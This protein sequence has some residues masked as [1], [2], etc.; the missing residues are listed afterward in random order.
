MKKQLLIIVAI[1]FAISV[2]AQKTLNLYKNDLSVLKFSTEQIDSIKV[3]NEQ[4]KLDIYQSDESLTNVTLSEID[5]IN[6]S[7]GNLNNLASI[8]TLGVTQISFN[9]IIMG[10]E[11]LSTGGSSVAEMGICWNNRKLPT[12]NRSVVK[13]TPDMDLTDIKLT[14]LENNTTYYARAFIKNARGV[15]YGNELSFTTKSGMPIIQTISAVYNRTSKSAYCVGNLVN[16]GTSEITEHGFCWS[17]KSGA[18]I[19]DSKKV[20]DNT[21]LGQYNFTIEDLNIDNDYFVR[22]YA[23]NASGTTYGKEFR[24]IPV[25]GNITY[26]FAGGATPEYMG[27]AKFKMLKQAMDS[28][29]Y[30]FNKYTGYTA[31]IRVDHHEGV[32]TAEASYR[33]Q[34]KFGANER[35]LFVG[36]AMHEMAHYF[37]S[38]THWKWIEYQDSG[39][40]LPVANALVNELTNGYYTKLS[41]GG[42][43]YWPF[44]CN[45]REE[46]GSDPG[47]FSNEK[48]LRIMAKLVWAMQ[49]DCGWRIE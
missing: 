31:N 19:N 9:N 29:C 23:T 41:A 14:G 46:V 20:M 1:F 11:V 44:G 47:G 3:S 49:Q 43:H 38:G 17:T 25:M 12:I 15:S 5:S 13:V 35:Y 22:A 32:P 4:T 33:G 21:A 18:T 42:Y 30:Y 37:G 26:H 2:S 28:A 6:F 7:D 36:T 27:E 40:N 34:L 10:L 8:K 24:V 45:Q 48:Y 39:F 16:A